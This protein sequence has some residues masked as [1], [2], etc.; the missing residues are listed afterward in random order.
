MDGQINEMSEPHLHVA[1]IKINQLN[2]SF[3]HVNISY[4][5]NYSTHDLKQQ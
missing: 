2:Q 5:S 4:K 3:I 1:L